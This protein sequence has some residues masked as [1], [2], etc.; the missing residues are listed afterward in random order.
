MNGTARARPWKLVLLLVAALA[1]VATMIA[2]DSRPNNPPRSAVRQSLGW[3]ADWR[4]YGRASPF[5]TPVPARPKLL[6]ASSAIVQRLL[7]FRQIEPLWIGTADTAADYGRPS[8]RAT[9]GDPVYVLRCAGR[10]CPMPIEGRRIRVPPGARPAGGTDGHMAVVQPD[11]WEYDLYE[12]RTPIPQ[13]GGVITT[14]GGGRTRID[15]RGTRVPGGATAARFGLL[16]GL[17]RAQEL[18]AGRIDHAL[19]FV[20][21]CVSSRVVPPAAGRARM[22]TSIG[23]PEQNAPPT[24]ARFQLALSRREIDALELP[25]WKRAIVRALA[26]YGMYLSDTGGGFL[27]QESGS[28]YTSFGKRDALEIFAEHHRDVPGIRTWISSGDGLRDY[29][30]DLAEGIPWQRLRV[31][32]PCVTQRTC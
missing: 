7:G 24:G 25:P 26:R 20:S 1:A 17:V 21:R 12:V 27:V 2:T 19:V 14:N 4:P 32:D 23:E 11:G 30:L 6:P 16:G 3:P 9:R 5:N 8:Y 22:C 29:A 28:T 31:L 10:Y 15:G 18:A 13:A